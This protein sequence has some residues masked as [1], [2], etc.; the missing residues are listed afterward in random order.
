MPNT[1]QVGWWSRMTSA[2]DR[3]QWTVDRGDEVSVSP[4]L[5]KGGE[6]GFK[7]SYHACAGGDPKCIADAGSN[8][9][10]PILFGGLGFYSVME[11]IA[12]V[13][14]LTGDRLAA[15]ETYLTLAR[16]YEEMGE[17]G[18]SA[19]TFWILGN[20]Q[21]EMGL[22]EVAATSFSKAAQHYK[23]V[24]DK[25]KELE[26]L[27]LAG[28]AHEAAGNYARAGEVYVAVAE[29]TKAQGENPGEMYLAAARSFEKAGQIDIAVGL[30]SK[31]ADNYG[32]SKETFMIVEAG[33]I[34]MRQA[35][36]LERAGRVDGARA[37]YAEAAEVFGI[38]TGDIIRKGQIRP[39]KYHETLFMR[40]EALEKAGM[41][42]EAVT[43]YLRLYEWKVDNTS[44]G[45]ELSNLARY[46]AATLLGELGQY[47]RA[48]D[49][50]EKIV[51][52]LKS[53]PRDRAP[54]G[55]AW[56]EY[57][58]A[59]MNGEFYFEARD[60]L[61]LAAGVIGM[62]ARRYE[63]DKFGDHKGMA[64][65]L[66]GVQDE[67]AGLINGINEGEGF[68]S[69]NRMVDDVID[70]KGGAMESLAGALGV[71]EEELKYA[72]R[73]GD[74]RAFK[75]LER[76]IGVNRLG[77]LADSQSYTRSGRPRE[78]RRDSIERA[79]ERGVGIGVGR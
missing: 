14:Q 79:A 38:V 42:E 72:L 75:L 1:Q 6:G 15:A 37:A 36:M 54:L 76:K 21:M 22:P 68:R 77:E 32:S 65:Y 17:L 13:H 11:G 70:A 78:E 44:N 2:V 5:T 57:G 40:G 29:L 52:D 60:N 66:R 55:D 51:E 9:K 10:F 64:R 48:A 49:V 39:E 12:R 69:I 35:Q 24:G 8:L 46:R 62:E 71:N 33:V 31:A 47:E 20:I 59:L 23:T 26:N 73:D 3:G 67:A 19:N 16:K 34:R 18:R 53:S 50:F 30:F 74:G 7:D 58:R 41:R 27:K 56:F 63:E 28:R 61:A 43:E 45:W 4:P 25:R